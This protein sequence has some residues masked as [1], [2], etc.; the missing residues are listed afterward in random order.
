MIPSVFVFVAQKKKSYPASIIIII[1]MYNN[2]RICIFVRFHRRN[3]EINETLT[4][5]TFSC[6][7][8]YLPCDPPIHCSRDAKLTL[9]GDIVSR[10]T[11][12]VAKV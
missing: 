12:L 11:M 10:I 3:L 9:G 4:N 7:G 5:F 6:G 8:D 2:T 1:I